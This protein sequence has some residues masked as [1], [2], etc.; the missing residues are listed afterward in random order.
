MFPFRKIIRFFTMIW[1]YL[2]DRELSSLS[3]RLCLKLYREYAE[4]AGRLSQELL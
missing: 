4:E 2:P 3:D 1:L